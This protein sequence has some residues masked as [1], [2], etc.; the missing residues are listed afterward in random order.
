MAIFINEQQM[1]DNNTFEY[2]DRIKSPTSRFLDTTPTFVTYYHISDLDSTTD[3]GFKDV[4]SILGFRSPIRFQKIEDFPIYGIDQ[5]SLQLQEGD[6]GLDSS[7]EGDAT[8]LPRTIKP[9]QNDFFIIPVLHEA[10]IFRIIE[11]QYD[12]IMPDNFYKITFKLETISNNDTNALEDQTVKESV[13][14][15]ENIGT[16]QNCIIEKVSYVQ[17]QKI[18]KMYH[19]LIEFYMAMFYSKRHNVFLGNLPLGKT[20]FDPFQATFIN[21]YHLF[22]EKRNLQTLLLT[23]QVEDS[24][25]KYKYNKSIYKYIELQDSRLLAPFYYITKPGIALHETS[26]YRWH[27]KTVQVLDIPDIDIKTNQQIF[28]D[29]FVTSIKLNAPLEGYASLIQS[30]VRGETLSP[31]QI[32]LDLDNELI[33]LNDSIEVFFFTPIIMYIIRS[34]IEKELRVK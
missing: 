7:Y 4:E 22:N 23:E 8:I 2:E 31:K 6:F 18:N 24:R 17:I 10:Y 16:E 13:C 15:L 29:E 19:E 20:L 28:S 25:A 9:Y 32:P 30:F 34:V 3:D 27:D 21:K 11:I 14:L 1:V 12:N 26:F 33:D 5:I